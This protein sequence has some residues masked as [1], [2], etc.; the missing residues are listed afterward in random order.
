M[1][2]L[3]RA[4]HA[5]WKE[6]PRVICSGVSLYGFGPERLLLKEIRTMTWFCVRTRFENMPPPHPH[7]P[8]LGGRQER[9]GIWI[10]G[11]ASRGKQICPL[12]QK[13]EVVEEVCLLDTKPGK[14]TFPPFPP[15]PSWASKTP[16]VREADLCRRLHRMEGPSEMGGVP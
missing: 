11:L 12:G 9:T 1:F 5:G 4:T 14:K 10:T 2:F 8:L 15:S 6:D 7:Q 13:S 16:V 3:L